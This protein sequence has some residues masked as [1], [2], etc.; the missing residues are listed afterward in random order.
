MKR[1]R[2]QKQKRKNLHGLMLTVWCDRNVVRKHQP[3]L[4]MT[5]C[6]LS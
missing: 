4:G 3:Q 2:N 6:N 1:E 5:S